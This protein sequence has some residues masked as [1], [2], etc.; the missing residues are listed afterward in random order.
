MFKSEKIKS[1]STILGFLLLL[2]ILAFSLGQK[3]HRNIQA[4]LAKTEKVSFHSWEVLS[5]S[6]SFLRYIAPQGKQ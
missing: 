6:Y 5:W 2:N 4:N 3:I 1:F